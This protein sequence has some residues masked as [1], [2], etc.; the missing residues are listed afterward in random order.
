MRWNKINQYYAQ[1][2]EFTLCKVGITKVTYELWHKS[3]NLGIFTEQID[4][5]KK[6]KELTK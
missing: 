3:T 1:N 2:G 6:F 5:L 4:A